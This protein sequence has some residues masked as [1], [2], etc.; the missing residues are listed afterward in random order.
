[1]S[2][3]QNNSHPEV[4]DENRINQ[5]YINQQAI[6]E[7]L[8]EHNTAINELNEIIIEYK[9][10]FSSLVEAQKS[11]L[12]SE[13]QISK[14]VVDMEENSKLLHAKYDELKNHINAFTSSPGANS[15]DL[16]NEQKV[17]TKQDEVI[18]LYNKANNMLINQIHEKQMDLT[19]RMEDNAK[20]MNNLSKKHQEV[21]DLA[22]KYEA[23]QLS[24]NNK[25][26]KINL[27]LG[28]LTLLVILLGVKLFLL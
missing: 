27:A 8:N 11:M 19:F 6:I 14:N 23:T 26:Q 16:E 25:L 1:M 28:V 3:Q 9:E 24:L 7:K 21:M 4:P 10:Y 22:A 18:T 17:I 12:A 2:T 15:L 20:L 13:S 5:L